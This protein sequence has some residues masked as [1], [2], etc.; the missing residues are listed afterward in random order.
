MRAIY[1]AF[2]VQSIFEILRAEVDRASQEYA[3]A[4]QNFWHISADVPTGLPH[5]DGRQRIENAS[6]AQT[7]AMIAYTRALRRFNEFLLNGTIPEDLRNIQDASAKSDG[8]G[9]L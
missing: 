2:M 7:S 9:A 6:H 8:S 5:P 4:K 3:K 1:N